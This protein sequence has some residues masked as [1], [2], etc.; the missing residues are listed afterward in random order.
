MF[1]S[2][3]RS[4]STELE[5]AL[6]LALVGAGPGS[7]AAQ[8]PLRQL[9][10][11][12]DVYLVVDGASANLYTAAKGM[13]L[14]QVELEEA[15]LYFRV[16][17]TASCQAETSGEGLWA[18]TVVEDAAAR[19]RRRLHPDALRQESA[20]EG[21]EDVA[22]PALVE[23]ATEIPVDYAVGLEGGGRLVVSGGS[24]SGMLGRLAR[25]TVLGW[26][27]LRGEE[28]PPCELRLLLDEPAA[29]RL[30]HLVRPGLRIVIVGLERPASS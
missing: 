5:L 30:H 24:S 20:L 18:L 26:R 23:E 8:A 9:V 1:P 10:S 27:R 21:E 29:Q 11:Q 28:A 4:I 17:G 25:A 2:V 13:V 19:H 7:S 12:R 22:Q 3:L 6:L 15:A 16:K 14:E